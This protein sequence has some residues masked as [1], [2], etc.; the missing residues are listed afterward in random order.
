MRKAFIPEVYAGAKKKKKKYSKS[1]KQQAA[2]AISTASATSN[3]SQGGML[4]SAIVQGST[5]TDFFK[6]TYGDEA[7]QKLKSSV[8]NMHYQGNYDYA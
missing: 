4:T 5:G 3:E 8:N 7:W 6:K 2:I 1:R